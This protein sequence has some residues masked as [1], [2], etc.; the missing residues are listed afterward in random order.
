VHFRCGRNAR[1][2]NGVHWR[3]GMFWWEPLRSIPQGPD[4]HRFPDTKESH[5]TFNWKFQ[6]KEQCCFL[7][8]FAVVHLGRLFLLWK[9]ISVDYILHL[10][11]VSI[12]KVAWVIKIKWRSLQHYM[13]LIHNTEVSALYWHGLNILLW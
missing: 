2:G 4:E 8:F 3:S 12:G 1:S 9:R 7:L 13:Y 6:G 10:Q 5:F 11:R